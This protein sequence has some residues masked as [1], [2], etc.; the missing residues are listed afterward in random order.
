MSKPDAAS[1][2]SRPSGREN[3]TGA[4]M[5]AP[6]GTGLLLFVAVPF[7]LAIWLSLHFVNFNSIVPSRW[8]G[9]QQYRELFT[10][11]VFYRS[12]INNLVFAA[13]VVPLQTALAIALALLV[14]R[15]M[16]GIAV[17]RALFFLPVVFPMALVAVIW[18]L[19]YSPDQLGLLN[20]VLNT[21]TF[22]HVG[23]HDWLGDPATA[24]AAII[25]MSIW[26]G[27]GL[28]MIIVLAGL[29]GISPD[30][31]EAAAIDSA[32]TWQRFRH[33]TLPGLRNSLVFVVMVTTIL[34]F[35]LFDQIYILTQGG[36]GDATSTIM[37]QAV[38]SA[39]TE[40]DVGQ[41]A[42]L[43]VVFFAVVLTLTLVQRRLLREER[44]VA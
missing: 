14:N 43:T 35:Q 26:Q 39:F 25:V 12:L 42:A 19:I 38:T 18:K 6:A 40:G 17:L 41:G 8:D 21:V 23:P 1:R 33:V 22:G 7:V 16:R 30:L 13:V 15:K 4:A 24:L 9:L 10:S 28:Q 27:V 34:S 5:M 2:A 36:P 37:Y 29:Q 31:Y 11:P 20:S 3:I 44:T 32:S